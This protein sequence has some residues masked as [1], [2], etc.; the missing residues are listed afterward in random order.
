[1]DFVCSLPDHPTAAFKSSFVTCEGCNALYPVAGVAM[2]SLP[3]CTNCGVAVF[4]TLVRVSCHCV[5]VYL[6]AVAFN[7]FPAMTVSLKRNEFTGAPRMY[8]RPP[9]PFGLDSDS[10]RCLRLRLRL[11]LSLCVYFA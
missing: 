9:F 6:H 11:R 7:G 8:P 4:Q 1:M 10:W 3:V 2:D 5:D